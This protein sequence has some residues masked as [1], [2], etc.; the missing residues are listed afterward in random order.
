LQLQLM[1]VAEWQEFLVVV[2]VET[3][4]DT[5]A[6]AADNVA[7]VVAYTAG[8]Q[9]TVAAFLVMLLQQWMQKAWST[10]TMPIAGPPS[11]YMVTRH[12]H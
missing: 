11:L 3:D 7:V 9:C 10:A 2:D 8:L 12:G 6:A 4:T 5:V 1:V